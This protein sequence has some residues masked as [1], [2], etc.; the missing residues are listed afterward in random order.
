M[1]VTLFPLDIIPR[2]GITDHMVVLVGILGGNLMLVFIVAA[3][4]Y[5]PTNRA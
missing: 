2:N 5:I 4:V 3:Q 1:R